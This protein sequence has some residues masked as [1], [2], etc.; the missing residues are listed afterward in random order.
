MLAMLLALPACNDPKVEDAKPEV[1]TTQALNITATTADLSGEVVA[2]NG[3]SVVERGFVYSTT[4][5][6]TIEEATKVKSGQGV[7]KYSITVGELEPNTTYHFK[8]YATNSQGTS[9]GEEL[10]FATTEVQL[11]EVTTTEALNITETTAELWGE[12][13]DDN[14]YRV[15]ERG[16]VYSTSENPTIEEATKVTSERGLGEY[17]FVVRELQSNTTYYFKA[18]ATNS[19]G[20]SY[21]EEL[22]FTTKAENSKTFNINNAVLTMVRVEGGTFQMGS[23]DEN[24]QSYEMPVHNVTLDDYYIGLC[25]VTNE[26]WEAVMNGRVPSPMEDPIWYENRFLPK[27]M[28][29]YDEC[30]DFVSKLNDLTGLEFALPTEAEWEYAARGGKKSKGYTYSGSNEASEVGW[31]YENAAT[32]VAIVGTKKSNE[33]GL[34]DMTGNVGEWCADWYGTYSSEDQT[35]PVGP[36]SGQFRVMRGGSVINF[37]SECRTSHRFGVEPNSHLYFVGFRLVL[38]EN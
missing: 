2:D 8:A 22:T 14:G 11:P 10:T 15:I 35:N 38:K 23:S 3:A 36:D 34:F 30:L 17:S 31:C 37:Y 19:Q 16:F 7:G 28:V 24:A 33:L 21:G 32:Q 13:V 27:A 25:E 12:V 1:T 20:T 26:Q 9:Y 5:N 29:S 6:P 18:Y 4:A